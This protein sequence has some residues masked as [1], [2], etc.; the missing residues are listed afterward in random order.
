MY[1][2]LVSIIIPVFN[3]SDY[4]KEC[5]NS[6][7]Q[8]TY[9]N[10]EVVVINDGSDDEGA[11][12]KIALSFGD[13]IRYFQKENGGV[14]SALN[15]GIEKMKGEWFSW[16]SH[17]DL[18][19]PEKIELQIKSVRNQMLDPERTIVSCNTQYIDAYGKKIFHPSPYKTGHFTGERIFSELCKGNIFYGCALLIPKDAIVEVNGFENKYRFIQDWVC[20]LELS[21]R[22]YDFFL[23]DGEF[24]KARIHGNQQTKKISNLQPREVED[25]LLK[26]VNRA[27]YSENK[28]VL[29]TILFNK[30]SRLGKPE[31]AQQ[32]ILRLKE[33]N[34]FNYN[35]KLMYILFTIWGDFLRSVKACYR[36]LFNR[37]YRNR[38]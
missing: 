31:I 5:I 9:N 27:E 13:K 7:L 10:V 1:N 16:L 26:I 3:G 25:Y 37:A 14:S 12:E 19:A 8:Q 20:W 34:L 17:D 15:F 23:L 21:L 2:P 28:F 35:D 18:Y 36:S 11:T 30:C 24:V 32:Y 33:L 38:N 4:L 29:K 22:G 6:A